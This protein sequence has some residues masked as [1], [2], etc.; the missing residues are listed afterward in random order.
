MTTN[1]K[2]MN[3]LTHKDAPDTMRRV[4]Y[5]LTRSQH[6][7]PLDRSAESAWA[8]ANRTAKLLGLLVAKLESEGKLSE[9]ELDTMLLAVAR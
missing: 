9:S 1:E 7:Q 3:D 6:L 5:T 2:L 4:F 8:T